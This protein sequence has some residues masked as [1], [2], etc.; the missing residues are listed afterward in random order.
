MEDKQKEELEEKIN[1]VYYNNYL[2]VI[3]KVEKITELRKKYEEKG[4]KGETANSF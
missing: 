1:E 4:G 3:E 2:T